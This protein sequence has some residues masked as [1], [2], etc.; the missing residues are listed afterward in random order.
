MNY[1]LKKV[2]IDIKN[3]FYIRKT[4]KKNLLT[5]EW[6]KYKLRADW[7]GRIYTVV[8]LPPE[9]MFSTDAPEEIRPAYVLEEIRPI[10]EYLTKLNLHEI[11]IPEIKPIPD[12]ISYLIIYKPYFQKL[13]WKW[14]FIRIF[15]ILIL[16][17]LDGKFKFLSNIWDFL[18]KSI[19]LFF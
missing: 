18:I 8:N 2:I 7:I 16:F 4:I 12:S 15:L 3:Y 14:I 17:W 10:N 1:P 13:S 5:V 19:N 6:N 11:I 9:V